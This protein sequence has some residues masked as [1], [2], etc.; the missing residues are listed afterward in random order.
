MKTD[1]CGHVIAGAGP[2][3][4][5]PAARP[6]TGARDGPRPR[7]AEHRARPRLLLKPGASTP[8]LAGGTGTAVPTRQPSC[9]GW[10]TT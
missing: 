7:R 5:V 4:C 2:V 9:P 8:K 10:R 6:R 3:S 1:T